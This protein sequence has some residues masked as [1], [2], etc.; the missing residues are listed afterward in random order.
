MLFFHLV[1]RL[2]EKNNTVLNDGPDV[3][4]N[5]RCNGR[6]PV[7]F[8]DWIGPRYFYSTEEGSKRNEETTPALVVS[9]ALHRLKSLRASCP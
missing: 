9:I 6:F 5:A 3:L 8:F 1:A 2:I 4:A 7:C